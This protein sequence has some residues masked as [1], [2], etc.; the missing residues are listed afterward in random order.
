[1]FYIQNINIKK[2]LI[3]LL[4]FTFSCTNTI[5]TS[6][7]EI[8]LA[9]KNQTDLEEIELEV[10]DII[11][12]NGSVQLSDGK[13]SKDVIF[14]SNSDLIKTEVDGKITALKEG[15]AIVKI[16]AKQDPTK[17]S[18]VNIKINPYVEKKIQVN[19]GT[20]EKFLNEID[21]S[22][23]SNNLNNTNTS[24]PSPTPTPI[25]YQLTRLNVY[26]YSPNNT[27]ID[28]ADVI[29]KSLDKT[30]NFEEKIK[31]S[32]GRAFFS[33]VPINTLLSIKVN[34]EGF[35]SKER[36]EVLKNTTEAR[37]D[38][39]GSDENDIYSI[40]QEP[41]IEK[42][43]I[44]GNILSNYNN[45]NLNNI[46]VP[47]GLETP[48]INSNS[49]LNI[50]I[51]FTKPINKESFIDAIQLKSQATKNN[52]EGIT[53]DKNN[54]SFSWGTDDKVVNIYGS[55]VFDD[56][57]KIIYVLS[58]KKTFSDKTGISSIPN[59]YINV[60]NIKKINNIIFSF[61]K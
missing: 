23:F 60:N 35:S 50:Q 25:N 41:E 40:Q 45:Y 8:P 54:L 48:N 55:I 18:S 44:N 39:G 31:S 27:I 56:L 16:A 51:N 29:V 4:L 58:F 33:K 24:N 43:L 10:G 26:L 13:L 49:N 47:T 3:L 11:Q 2:F 6:E 57:K 42:V 7:I 19:S 15:K 59:K 5:S 38:F 28:D 34:K 36:I 52:L 12:L 61:E 53:L 22:L 14:E 32:S 9:R 17:F 37:I 46:T 20:G 1:M 30:I 21:N